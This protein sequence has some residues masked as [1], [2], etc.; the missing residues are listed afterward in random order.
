MRNKAA[1]TFVLALMLCVGAFLM[2]MTTFAAN[3]P[4]VNAWLN[5][6]TLRIEVS[7]AGS[8]VESVYVDSR[9]FNYL[10]DSVIEVNARDAHDNHEK[11]SVYAVD[12]SGV[13][14]NVVQIT[15]P[16]YKAPAAS[17]SPTPPAGT[18]PLPNPTP[19]PSTPS[20]WYPKKASPAC[21]LCTTGLCCPPRKRNGA[22]VLCPRPIPISQD[23]LY[24]VTRDIAITGINRDY[25][26]THTNDAAAASVNR[27]L[28]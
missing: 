4:A 5:G 1:C 27:R 23:T 21:A 15:N 2:P 12:F 16:Y 19:T 22:R 3:A 25:F 13:K 10:V 24:Q 14:S 11:I 26:L 7:D 17:P 20:A 18:T 28:I 6:D 9:R 8:G